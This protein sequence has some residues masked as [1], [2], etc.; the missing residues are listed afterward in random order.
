MSSLVNAIANAD[1]AVGELEV[2]TT[3][4]YELR[5]E[6]RWDG[7]SHDFDFVRHAR[8]STEGRTPAGVLRELSG[9]VSEF[10]A[11]VYAHV[12]TDKR[13]R[14]EDEQ[15]VSFVRRG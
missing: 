7:E 5:G 13:L 10:H 3:Q 9:K 11:V 6:L 12:A 15:S 8:A 4:V 1:S 2:G 14:L